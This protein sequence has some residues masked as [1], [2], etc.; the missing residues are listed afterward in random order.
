MADEQRQA[1]MEDKLPETALSMRFGRLI[2]K[3]RF[4]SLMTLV[5]ILFFF[6]IPLVNA[7]YFNVTGK[8]LPITD[9]RFR[10][11]TRARDQWPEHPFIH[12]VDKFAGRFGTASYV[13]MAVVKKDGDIYDTEFLEKVDR[14][15]K[16]VDEAPLVNHYQVQS[17]AHINTRVIRI[18]PD[19]ALT[20]EPLMEEPPAD[21]DEL[22]V[23]RETVHQN[24][25]RIYGFLV[26]RDD[27]A[28]QITTGFVTHRLDNRKAY[29][30]VFNYFRKLEEEE[31]ADGTVDIYLSGFPI[32]VGWTYLHAF[33]IIL[34]L[35][36]TI[37]LLFFLLL[38]YFRRLHGVSIPMV[39]GLCAAI[40]GMGFCGWIGISL[41]PLVLVIPLLITSRCISH[42]IQMAERFF[43]DFEAEVEARQRQKGRELTEQETYEAK[44]ETATSALSKL[45]LPGMLAIL[46]DAVGLTVILITTMKQMFDLGLFGSL[47]VVAIFFNVIILHPIMIMYL[48][49]PHDFKHFTP[50]WMNAILTW[51]G[52]FTTGAARWPIIV[53]SV[54]F[55]A[56]ISIYVIM[57]TTIGD[58]RPGTPLFWPDH[59]FNQATAEIAKRFG[60]VDQFTVFVDGD[61]KGASSDGAVLQ[62]MEA[63]ERY[64]KKYAD[65]GA[66]IS[67]VD[68]IRVFWETNHYGDPKWGFVPDSASAVSR[69]IFQLMQSSTPGALRPYLTDE[70]EDANITFFFADHRG[71][72][73]RKAV[74]FSEEFIEAN[75]MG[76]LSIRLRTEPNAFLDA[77]YYIFGPLL[78]PRARVIEVQKAELNEEQEVTGYHVLESHRVDKWTEGPKREDVEKNV[79]ESI[80][81]LGS[82]KR[83][84]VKL[85]SELKADLKLRKDVVEKTLM[86]LS[87]EF[88]YRVEQMN[89]DPDQ[90]ATEWLGKETYTTVGDIV[91]HIMARGAVFVEEEWADPELG[92]TA[93]TVRFCRHYC[94]YEL[95]VKNEKFKDPSW[96]P[97]PTGS[98]T[99]GAEFVMAGGMMGILAAVNDEVERGHVANILLIFLINYLFVAVS[100]RSNAAGLVISFSVAFATMFSLW[101]MVV[102]DT[103]LNVNTLPVQSVGVGVGV[104]YALYLT[105]RIRQ[106]YSWC[107][108]LDEGIRRAISTTGM[109]VSFTATTLVG[110]I[111]A[112]V[113]SNLRFQA[114]MAQLLTILMI[115]NL[116]AAV[117]V[118]PA[119]FSI[120]RPTFF[121][122]SLAGEKA[123][124]NVETDKKAATGGA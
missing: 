123:Q 43:E 73:I 38:A 88:D 83:E 105:D 10:M 45:M 57:N 86:K 1:F 92:I 36:A 32:L 37:V 118:V 69:V 80:I 30:D 31:E 34:F 93:Q 67:L 119:M 50:R 90:L 112:W 84:E 68:I 16:A 114:E 79:I 111:G 91:D 101:W 47:W 110:G 42:T 94:E 53:V 14:L 29:E 75:P 78:F 70:Q 72:T 108:D 98:W 33:E 95:W 74:H 66:V 23:F 27:T 81:A 19:G 96:N 122:T 62:R 65:P 71:E 89:R 82:K 21:D 54:A 56:Y 26:S 59:P 103:G 97:Q 3:Y 58:A 7:V 109:A 22:A 5:S 52:N 44:V 100:Y 20:A 55:F 104:D 39:A 99:R 6:A 87:S 41:D 61:Q 107:G 9:A 77:S 49:P 40:W 24:P 121:A 46:T 60:G 48:P 76:R 117:T 120:F 106:E 13:A 15:T 115:V 124:P 12:A 102:R 25:G 35:L 4:A 8:T 2:T 17:I 28:V 11:D 85:D 51:I 64:V 63:M 116:I 113:F 18:E